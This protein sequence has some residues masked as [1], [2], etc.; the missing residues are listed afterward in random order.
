M[1]LPV[2]FARYE[3]QEFLGGGMSHVYRAVDSVIGR[4]VA[5]KILT[6]QGIKDEETKQ[7]F[8]REARI[9]GTIQHDNIVTVHDYGEEQGYPYIV[10]E[11]LHGEDLREAIRKQHTG[12]LANKI[13]LGLEIAKALEY[14]HQKGIIHRDIK[15]ENVYVEQSGRAK[16][17]DFGIAKT[18]GHSLTKTGNSMGTPHYMAPEQVM[19]TNITALVDIYSYGMLL[20]ELFSGVKPLT[21]DTL[22]RLFYVIL[23]EAPDYQ[24]LIA[25]GTPEGIVGLIQRCVAKKPEERLQSFGAVVEILKG[26]QSGAGFALATTASA[27]V[28]PAAPVAVAASGQKFPL[29]P[30]L[31][32][33]G[34]A[35]VLGGAALWYFLRS[36]PAAPV[37]KTAAVVER[38]ALK[39]GPMVPVPAGEF[40]FSAGKSPMNLEAFSIDKTEVAGQAYAEFVAATGA[41]TPEGLSPQLP[42]TNVTFEQAKAYCRWAG[43]Q[44]PNDWQWEKAARGADGRSFPWGNEMKTELAV[45]KG[46]PLAANGPVAVDAMP[47]GASPFGALHMAGN[48]WEWVDKPH[49]P[50]SLAVESL[51]GAL[52]PAP[53]AQE[54][55][56]Y[57]KGGSYDREL[58]AGVSFEFVS[59][60]GRFKSPNIG[61]RCVSPGK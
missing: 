12:D 22:Q 60:P 7:R 46:N 4:P 10:L 45:V 26:I 34:L 37:E 6:E 2:R 1:Q 33:A 44:L 48:V 28:A 55:W 9:S 11:F 58:A 51:Q 5:V 35:I 47:G 50:S 49:T 27:T 39:G 42:V 18:E 3:L 24:P 13:R 23:N 20:Y 8:L 54:P 36:K 29:V 40:L 15:P 56:H 21:G 30:V 17:M 43:K 57:I 59:L 19:G 25:A 16:L 32:A 38:P 14:V 31:G 52:Q 61:F 53:T 41:P